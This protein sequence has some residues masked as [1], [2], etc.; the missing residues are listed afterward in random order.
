MKKLTSISLLFCIFFLLPAGCKVNNVA[1]AQNLDMTNLKDAEDKKKRFFDFMRPIIND[2]N[3]R[4][5]LLRE[6]LLAAKKNNYRKAFVRRTAE[7]YGL[8]WDTSNENWEKLLQHVDAVALELALAQSANESAWGQSR[9]A[10]EGNN[11]FGQWCYKKGCGMIP[12]DRDHGTYHE[13]SRFK[14]VN[15]SVRSY[16]R[17]INTGPAYETLRDV[18]KK[19]RAAGNNPDAEAQ[20]G[21]LLKYSQR[22]ERYVKEIRSMIRINRELMLGN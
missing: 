8:Q 2:E 10:Q 21:G 6:S 22:G 15:S 14:N 11:F 17:N 7:D 5:L 16:I 4:V 9:F 12:D 19:N 18:R 3:N 1:T 20:A 13:V